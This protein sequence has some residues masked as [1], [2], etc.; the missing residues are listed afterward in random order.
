MSTKISRRSFLKSLGVAAASH[1]IGLTGLSGLAFAM[2]GRV[3]AQDLPKL[4]YLF[5]G[6]PQPDVAKVQ[7]A[8][9][10]YMADRVGATI[11]LRAIEWGAYDSQ[12]SLI[13]ASAEKYD[14]AFTAPWINNYY[15]NV[16]QEYLT[17]LDELL[18][19]QA[20]V[21]LASMTPETWEAAR[22]GGHIY[23]A[24][25]QQIFVKPFGPYVRK[26]VMDAIG[27]ED[28]FMSM[29]SWDQLDP[30]LKAV[31]DYVEKDDVL[32]H[33]SYNLAQI[34][35][36]ESWNFDPQDTML[37]VRSDDPT[38]QV[39]I[40]S[41][42][43]EYRQAAEM[44]RRWYQAGYSPADQA[45]WAEMDAAW[46]AGLYAVR[47]SDIVKPG[48]EAEVAARWGH[49]VV[50]KAIAE[51]ILTTGGVTA[52]MNGISS[53]SEHPELA[54]KFLELLNTDP[55]FFN[56]LAKGIEG[57]HWEWADKERQLIKPAGGAASF[58]DTGYNPNT[59]WMFGNVF[60]SYYTDESQV[61]AWPATAEL[62]RNARPSP[63]LGF[64][65]DRKA[66]ETEIASI[67]AVTQEYAG[68]LGGGIVDVEEGLANLNQALKDAGIERVRDEMQK[69]I[70]AW[71]AAKA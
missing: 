14:L 33:V 65:F 24:I 28:E 23:G 6:S 16:S 17:P 57:V 10:A 27:L 22:V 12:I 67:S 2:S 45:Q 25:N 36:A 69:Q 39:L 43:D 71:L 26:D 42:T 3:N 38:A 70:D 61:G 66:V 19:E 34:M 1:G 21:Y 18:P 52:T 56:M 5:P 53:V 58:G 63:V 8:L 15:T 30:I 29:T 68:P 49:P 59:D 4:V 41:E 37:V 20:P 60:N 48:G 31:Y 9:N 40:F 54:M 13:N 44:V 7:E 55:V 50:A 46:Q 11:E 47:I 32:T 35:T 62:N 64:T 51:P